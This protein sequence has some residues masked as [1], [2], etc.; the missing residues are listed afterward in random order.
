MTNLSSKFGTGVR[1]TM[2]VVS[3]DPND[4][5]ML[6]RTL[7]G[8]NVL[9]VFGCAEAIEALKEW[10]D[11][12][13]V[14]CERDLPDGSWTDVLAAVQRMEHGSSFI[15][16]SEDADE[17]LW[18]DVLRR[19]GFDV[20]AKPLESGDIRRIMPQAARQRHPLA[21]AQAI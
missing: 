20:V 8:W 21:L 2:L 17:L 4:P 19:G 15:V 18:A 1:T 11:I 6:T 5:P 14:V 9:R 7:V 3:S 16:M 13:V 10:S 12:A